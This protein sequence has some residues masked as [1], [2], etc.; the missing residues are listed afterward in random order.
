MIKQSGL[1]DE[2]WYLEQYPDVAQDGGDPKEH[3]VL[4]GAGEKRNPGPYFN[5]QWYLATYPDVGEAGVNPLLHFVRVGM[6][7]GR[8]GRREDL[9]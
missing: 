1:F 5:T 9:N 4:Y 8:F 7:E 2:A 6:Q 3:Y